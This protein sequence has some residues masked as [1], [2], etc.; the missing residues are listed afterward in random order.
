MLQQLTSCNT[1]VS[2]AHCSRT[3]LVLVVGAIATLALHR[4]EKSNALN[5]DSFREI[6]EV[7]VLRGSLDARVALLLPSFDQGV[8]QTVLLWTQA[9]AWIQT[10]PSVRV[11]LLTGSGRSFCA[12]GC[13]CS[14]LLFCLPLAGIHCHSIRNERPE[15]RLDL[16]QASTCPLPQA[17]LPRLKKRNVPAGPGS[18]CERIFCTCRMRSLHA[19]NAACP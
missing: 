12:G 14:A 5:H 18:S 9:L 19:N 16:P 4:P 7:G 13:P 1:V 6:P 10:K 8:L 11:V 17:S 15:L 2:L 3:R